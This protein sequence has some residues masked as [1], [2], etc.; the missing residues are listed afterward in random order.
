MEVRVVGESEA[1]ASIDRRAVRESLRSAFA[2]LVQG[3]SVQPE[4]TVTV[5]PNGEGDCIFYPGVIWDL[6]L[7]GVKVSPYISSL[8]KLGESP[9][10]AY[11]LLLSAKTGRPKVLCDSYAL[12]TARTA[13]TTALALEYLVPGSARS[14]AVIGSGKVAREH[15]RYVLEQH[16]WESVRVFSPTLAESKSEDGAKRRADLAEFESATISGSAEEAVDGADVVML[17]TSS[18]TPVISVDWLATNTVVTSI[19][20]NAPKAHELDPAAINQFSVFC[21]YRETAPTTAGEMVIATERGEWSA[22][23]LV[24]DLPELITGRATRPSSGRVFF[25]STGLGI[26]DL[27]IANLLG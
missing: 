2:G 10:T 1:L 25:R 17:C 20:T 13:A 3:T 23:E 16:S 21:D 4:Q 22:N 18:G 11:T 9:V 26:E 27:A 19:S 24:G 7:V 12:T 15:M 14:L 8:A 6:D 5:F